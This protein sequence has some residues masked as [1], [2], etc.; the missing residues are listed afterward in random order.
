MYIHTQSVHVQ[1]TCI[2]YSH[3]CF[4]TPQKVK[5]LHV[6]VH[7]TGGVLDCDKY[8]H[9]V[10]K[11]SMHKSPK[12]VRF[13]CVGAVGESTVSSVDHRLY[14]HITSAG[15]GVRIWNFSSDF[16]TRYLPVSC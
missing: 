5:H 12:P 15:Q 7:M 16:N 14:M 1:C 4:S 8:W 13:T 11:S 6:H 9:S 3:N 10:M 2:Y